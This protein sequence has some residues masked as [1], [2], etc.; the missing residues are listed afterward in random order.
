MGALITGNAMFTAS[1]FACG[2]Y[3]AAICLILTSASQKSPL[4]LS[5]RLVIFDQATSIRKNKVGMRK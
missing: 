3:T 4:Q 5:V 1:G 2:R